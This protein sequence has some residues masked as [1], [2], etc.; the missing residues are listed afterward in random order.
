MALEHLTLKD[1]TQI[2]RGAMIA[3]AANELDNDPNM[4]PNPEQFDPLRSYR[5]RHEDYEKNK[6]RF[7]AGQTS[8]CSLAF[9]YG[10]QA[11]PGRY[12]S[13]A[14]VKLVLMRMLVDFEFK[15]PEGKTS[16]RHIHVQENIFTDPY[17]KIMMRVRG[18]TTQ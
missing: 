10:S 5:K 16:V 6:H 12:F 13:I 9:G 7:V 18:D 4:V 15:F 14:E 8:A 2:P 3:W 17:A 1:G 11:C